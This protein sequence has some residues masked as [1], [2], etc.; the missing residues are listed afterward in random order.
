MIQANNEKIDDSSDEISLKELILKM[1]VWWRYLLSKWLFILIVGLFGSIL[2]LIYSYFQKPTYKAELSFALEDE[3]SGGGGLGAAM[4]LA[5][6]F[7]FDLGGGS[8]GGAFSGDNLLTLMKSRSMVEGALLMPVVIN[9]KS[10]TLAELYISFNQFRKE[11]ESKPEL[12]NIQFLSNVDRSKFSLQQDSILGVFYRT[13][14]KSVLSVDK[15]DKKLSIITVTVTSG[16]ELF[17]KFFTE[18][19][20]KTV[21]DFYVDTK[22]KKSTQNVTILQHQTD[23]VRHELDAAIRGVANSMDATPNANPGRQ[24][25]KVTSQSKQVNVTANTTILGE[26]VK[27]LEVSK[28]ALRNETPL[29]QVIDRPILPLEKEKFRK[30]KGIIIGGLIAGFLAILILIIKKGYGKR[31]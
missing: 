10:E 16:N 3:K 21:S 26:L 24:I 25:L 6:Q 22:T 2:G 12:R 29:I 27:N 18:V 17:S 31:N 30:I 9:G 14:V 1:K 15:V 13:I 4:G 20:V 8:G 19:L 23:S 11:W 7:G 28:V 5:S